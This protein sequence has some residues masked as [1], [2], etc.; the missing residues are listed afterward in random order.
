VE[1]AI[2]KNQMNMDQIDFRKMIRS[3][4]RKCPMCG[5]DS[6]GI[7]A[8]HTTN[9]VRQCRDCLHK[10]DRIP[11]PPPDKKV[12]YLDQNAISEMA[13]V[14]NPNLKKNPE[15]SVHPVWLEL[16]EK[17]QL[18]IQA[19]LVVCPESECHF[20][21]S[22]VM[23]S[24][25]RSFK[26][27]YECFSGGVQFDPPQEIQTR[28]ISH[29]LRSWLSKEPAM[30]MTIAD[31]TRGE[32]NAWTADLRVSLDMD[33]SSIANV[34]RQEREVAHQSLC[35]VFRQWQGD[36]QLSFEDWVREE[37]LGVAK[38]MMNS[39]KNA[40]EALCKKPEDNDAFVR[41]TQHPVHR[42]FRELGENGIPPQ[43]QTETACDFFHSTDFSDIPSVKVSALMFAAVAEKAAHQNQ[44]NPPDQGFA[45]D[46]AAISTV[47]PFCDA[48]FV[49]KGC[50]TI[51]TQNPVR[52][53]LGFATRVYSANNRADFL[54][55]LDGIG[56]SASS[57]H[58]GALKE[59]Y[60]D[61]FADSFKSRW[62]C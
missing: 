3:P 26:G 14:D 61:Q 16:K 42:I 17:L 2:K 49:D 6:Y 38:L 7:L 59:V 51:L 30:R 10:S 28:Q 43:K 1:R 23:A 31:V 24:A 8:V 25:Y 55:Y 45:K 58:I 35:H 40:Q 48:V 15:R 62:V 60:G 19:Q 9:Y 27:F 53:R 32:I 56:R 13:K 36:K 37:T 5:K 54:D 29:A 4:F 34:L 52:D 20:L 44:K 11:L 47:L 21:E 18:L 12:V 39:Y 41:Y 50:W 57:E 22:L 46:V 33:W